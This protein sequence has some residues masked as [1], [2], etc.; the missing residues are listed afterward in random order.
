MPADCQIRSSERRDPGESP[1][2]RDR[3]ISNHHLFRIKTT[4]FI[5]KVHP[6]TVAPSNPPADSPHTVHSGWIHA[7]VHCLQTP[8]FPLN[9]EYFRLC[10][11]LPAVRNHPM[12]NV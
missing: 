9:R 8:R 7:T 12:K 2:S 6:V 4:R 5:S 10:P 11:I 3:R 1:C